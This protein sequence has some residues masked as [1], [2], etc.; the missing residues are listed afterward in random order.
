QKTGFPW[1]STVLAPSSLWSDHDPFV[2][3]NAPWFE[4]VLRLGGPVLARG[5][6]R[7]ME[8]MTDSWLGQFYDFRR[9]LGLP[10]GGSPIFDGQFS[11]ELNLGICS[12]VMCQPQSDWPKN[13]VITGFAFYDKKDGASMD[14]ELLEFLQR[15]PAPIVFT[16]GSAAVHVAG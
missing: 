12:K 11:P 8:K 10:T 14:A 13:T 5:F 16:L 3:P 9:E 15:G 1:V 7:L 6:K 4:P 2:P